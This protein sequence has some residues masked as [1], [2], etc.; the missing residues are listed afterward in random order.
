MQLADRVALVTGAGSGIGRAS[1]LLLAREGAK[2]AA[3]GRTES[4]LRDAVREIEA[5][6]GEGMPIVA[7]IADPPQMQDTMRRIVERW[8]RLDIV[9]ANAGVN[10]VWAAL[11]DLEPEEWD[12]T[13][14][15]NLTGTFLTVK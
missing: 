10:G 7:D 1:A 4:Q 8:A 14:R 13:I 2:V 15:I 3:L 11:E 12:R 9:V 5:A 6:G